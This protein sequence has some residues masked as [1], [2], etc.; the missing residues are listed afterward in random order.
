MRLAWPQTELDHDCA[1]SC[2]ST[3]A[4]F[5]YVWYGSCLLS[6][7]AKC[8]PISHTDVNNDHLHTS[9]FSCFLY[10]LSSRWT[11][12]GLCNCLL[13]ET[14]FPGTPFTLMVSVLRALQAAA[15]RR[16]LRSD[17][18]KQLERSPAVKAVGGQRTG[19]EKRGFPHLVLGL[20]SIVQ[21]SSV[22]LTLWLKGW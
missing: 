10:V 11:S 13:W 20:S 5:L 3:K 21:R 9:T 8:F 12:P 1:G 18:R 19:W 14:G 15:P 2:R 17:G 7:L 4:L 6:Q 22:C 16:T